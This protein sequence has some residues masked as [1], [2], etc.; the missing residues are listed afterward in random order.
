MKALTLDNPWALLMALNLKR[1]ETR[2]WLT[3]YRGE[4]AIHA[5]KRCDDDAFGRFAR[6]ISEVTGIDELL[7]SI[8]GG[9]ILCVVNLFDCKASIGLTPARL[10]TLGFNPGDEFKFGNLSASRYGW[11]TKD[12]R[13]LSTPVP[14]RGRQRIWNVPPDVEAMVRAQLCSQEN[15]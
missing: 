4:L 1:I 9:Y 6:R 7:P 13:R 3:R 12:V 2:G 11:L 14:C 5:G 10:T 15:L 8:A